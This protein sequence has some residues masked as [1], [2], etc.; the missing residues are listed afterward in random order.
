MKKHLMKLAVICMIAALFMTPMSIIISSADSPAGD[1]GGKQVDILF[2]HDTHSH[3]NSFLTV[4]DEQSVT[5]GGFA[6]IKALI[7]Q[8]KENNPDT[9]YVDAGDFSM[10]TLVQTIFDTEAP[11]LRMLGSLECEVTTLG[12]HEFD[13]RSGG[14]A[15]ALKA[16]AASGDPVPAMVLCNI[17]WETME[18][19]GLTE[20]QQ[21]LKD[22]FEIYGMKDYVVLTKGDVKIAVLGIFGEDSLSCAPTCV[23]K[24]KNASVAAAATVK[25]IQEKEDVDMI[26]CV[27]H[28]G[29]N[30]KESKSEDE[31]LAKAVPDIDLIISGH[32]HTT[33]MQPIVHGSTYIVS[34]GEYGKNLGTLNMT[35]LSD[36]RWTM[37]SYELIPITEEIP[38]DA[39][40]QDKIDSFMDVV[41]STYLSQF[42]YTRDYVLAQ[43]TVTFSP[44]SDLYY[45]HTEHN[46]G[47][48]LAD[49][50]N[51]AVENADDFDGHPVDVAIVPSGCVR[52]SYA[53]GDITVEDVFN[54]YSLGIGLD[55]IP[56]YPLIS[57]YL[58]GA[59]LKI[60]AEIDASVSDF[61]RSA[62]LYMNGISFSY[63]PHRLILNKV[64]DCYLTDDEGNRVEIQDDKLYRV[65]CDLYS[66]QMLGA[67]TDVS[68]GILSIQPKFAD[69]T[70]IENIEDAIILN[71][72]QEI[73]AWVAIATYLESLEDTNGDGIADVP[74]YYASSL[75]RKVVEDSTAISDLLKKPNKYAVIIIIV[76]III[77]VLA[78]LLI[79]AIIKLT[80]KI[81]RK[82]NSQNK[83]ETNAKN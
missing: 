75:D 36:G 16:A 15:S 13:Y 35:Q 50:F 4:Q 23:L 1:N 7:N 74:E 51:Y 66:G 31:I 53:I 41:D 9:L 8:A 61:M 81:V 47:N 64:T 68:Y 46:L 71:N 57:M 59:E 45:I 79:T 26:V 43:N 37:N 12:N 21:L 55:G 39:D 29:T 80:R 70:P 22:A 77:I 38:T 73:K 44:S 63:N 60:G 65:V 11:E 76:I 19:E 48:I 83:I 28:S 56:G 5:L 82:N 27:S 17:D 72:G 78:I 30:E 69:G 18:A 34:C 20:E 42:G 24:F 2:T 3:L 62:R 14:L 67:V 6:H 25:E 58:T 10:G 32:T 52:D 54:S 40:A 49:S 33:L